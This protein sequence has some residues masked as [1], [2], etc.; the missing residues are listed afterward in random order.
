MILLEIMETFVVRLFEN[1]VSRGFRIL[2]QGS[3][4]RKGTQLRSTHLYRGIKRSL[5]VGSTL[6]F[7]VRRPIIESLIQSILDSV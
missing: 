1:L 7:N 5:L 6:V 4:R 2:E 3:V